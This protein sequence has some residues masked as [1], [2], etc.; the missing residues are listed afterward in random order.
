MAQTNNLGKVSLTPRGA[1]DSSHTYEALDVLSYNGSGYIVLQSCTG[2]TPPNDTYYQLIAS[3]GNTG[4]TGAAGSI[5]VGTVTTV[6]RSGV[7]SVVNSGTSS[8]AVFDFQFAIND[9]IITN[10]QID[11]LFS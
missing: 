2:V 10:A 9:E 8:N 7:T 6:A 3:K 11:A 5:S 1:Y 4:A